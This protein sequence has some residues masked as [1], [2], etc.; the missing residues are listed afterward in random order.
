M[1][2]DEWQS[3]DVRGV[4]LHCHCHGNERV[5]CRGT[6]MI[7]TETNLFTGAEKLMKPTILNLNQ[8]CELKRTLLFR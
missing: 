2:G 3:T 5:T 7:L 8:G 4:V 1:T 6:G